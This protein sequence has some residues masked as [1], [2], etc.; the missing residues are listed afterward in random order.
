MPSW[1]VAASGLSRGLHEVR[2]PFSTSL[3]SAA[4]ISRQS[5]SIVVVGTQPSFCGRAQARSRARS[6]ASQRMG[7]SG[8]GSQA[9]REG[10]EGGE[11]G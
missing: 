5:S 2:S 6:G 3:M 7:R 1:H 4:T 8:R 9:P 11:G 10:G